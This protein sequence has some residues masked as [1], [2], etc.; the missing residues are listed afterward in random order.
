MNSA[1]FSKAKY[2]PTVKLKAAAELE[3]RRRRAAGGASFRYNPV[4]YIH[5]VLHWEPWSGEPGQV[6]VLEAYAD[7]LRTQIEQPGAPVKNWIRVE[8]GHTVGKTRLAA[9]IVSHFFDSFNPAVIYCF[10]PG[11][12][13]INDL[14][15]KYVR[16]D[17]RANNLPGRVLETPE[18]KHE[19]SHFVKGR[20]TSDAHGR[21]TERVQ[22]QHEEHIMFVIDEAEGVAD[23]VFEAVESMTSGGVSVVLMLANP[24]TRTSRFHKLAAASNVQSFRISCLNHP[25]VLENREVVPGAVKR[26]YVDSMLE[27]HCEMITEHDADAQ[28]FELPWQ[29]GTIY[30]PDPE[31][32]F[33]V[34]GVAPANVSD[35]TFLPVGRY[36]AATKRTGAA[37]GTFASVG[38]DV[39]RYGQDYGAVYVRRDNRLWRVAQLYHQDTTVYARKIADE[40]KRLAADGVTHLHVR[41]DAGGGYGGGVV[42]ALNADEDTQ[43]LFAEF[44]VFE[45]HFNGTPTD[46]GAYADRATEIYAHIAE[47]MHILSV[48]NAPDALEQDLCERTYKWVKVRGVDVKKLEPKD[49]FKK[50]VKRSPDDGDGA[51]LAAAPV[52]AFGV[53]GADLV[54][55]L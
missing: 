40:A 49:D 4:G 43:R 39:A 45:V 51:A 8:A 23:F 37:I 47:A 22:G 54:G 27:K 12:D 48:P 11:Y 20:A 17:R 13:Q 35:N 52:Y 18:I 26:T 1:P 2:S 10:A 25:N 36:E 31:F 44:H 34:L 32:M 42:D 3:L 16:A 28:T 29:P 14:L 15:F 50:R 55:F 7:A 53:S 41:V 30:R 46:E 6:E 5:T 9:G 38:V 19:A 33:R 21:G 24:R